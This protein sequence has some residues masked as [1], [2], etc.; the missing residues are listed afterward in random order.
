[1]ITGSQGTGIV[2]A[3]AR[4]EEATTA[5]VVEQPPSPIGI[6]LN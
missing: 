5:A 1:M 3:D 4:T 6:D 2:E